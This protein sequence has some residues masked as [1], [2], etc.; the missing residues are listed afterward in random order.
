MKSENV[1]G[2]SKAP[3]LIMEIKTPRGFRWMRN[4]E[5]TDGESY[6]ADMM[7]M[8]W[9]GLDRGETKRKGDLWIRRK[10]TP[11]RRSKKP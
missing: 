6:A 4:G 10:P 2:P 9:V 11:T 5:K 8:E 7:N 3:E 1:A